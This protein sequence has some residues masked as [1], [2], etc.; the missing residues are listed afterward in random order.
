[1]DF[2]NKAFAQISDLFRSM[3]PGARITAGLLLAVVIISFGYLFQHQTSS[4]D[5]YLMNGEIPASSFQSIVAAL[6]KANLSCTVEG[7]KIKVARGQQ[8]ACMAALAEAKALPPNFGSSVRNA[9]DAGGPFESKQQRDLRFN[10]ALQEELSLIIRS[11]PGI[12]SA[13]VLLDTTT[14]P[15][16]NHEQLRTASVAVKPVGSAPLDESRVATIQYLVVGSNAGMKPEDVV[17]ADLN[18]GKIYHGGPGGG[19]ALGENQYAADTLKYERDLKAKILNALAYIPNL[20]VDTTVILDPQKS[21][22]TVSLDNKGKPV[23]RRTVEKS[24]TH[25]RDGGAPGGR[26]GMAAQANTATS[27]ASAS[28][29]SKG[30]HDEEENTLNEQE[31]FISQEHS[32][33]ESVG[34]TPKLAR[35]C[36]GIPASYFEKVWREKN[37]T[38]E[39]EEPKTPDQ[40][41]LDL[42]RD[43]VTSRV[44]KHVAML[45]PLPPTE[46][47]TDLTE[48]VAVT[49]FPDIKAAEIP[50]PAV[51]QKALTWLGQYWNTLGM[52]G[53]VLVSLVMLRSM[54]RSEAPAE[55]EPSAMSLRVVASEA[56]EEEEEGEAEGKKSP[57]AAAARRLHHRLTGS[58]PSLRDEL[59]ELVKED[60]DAAANILRTWIG[61][62]G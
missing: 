34:L 15:G 1:M 60:P 8:A 23:A 42:I 57:D 54:V 45:L 18:D 56:G 43:D 28:T 61:Q 55:S 31:N 29:S 4:G 2:L 10:A 40:A 25:S 16:F 12:D 37:P 35:V 9:I 38:K 53:L 6:G 22:R 46:G 36:V 30:S 33:K 52:V 20:T 21:S 19:G 3:T 41:A 5:E 48:L 39:G 59:S 44:R 27:L 14:K 32:E 47:V 17:V 50:T 49:A 26:P 13:S 51:T 11:M 62:V 58:G 7:S 24:Q